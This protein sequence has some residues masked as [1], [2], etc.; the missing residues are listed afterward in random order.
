MA[1]GMIT[2]DEALALIDSR[3]APLGCERVSMEEAAGR[4]LATDAV[5]ALPSPRHTISAMDGY[6]VRLDE[7]ATGHGRQSRGV[8]G[9]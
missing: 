1:R 7:D 3:V 4:T 6:A 2:F 5:A 9:R 8:R